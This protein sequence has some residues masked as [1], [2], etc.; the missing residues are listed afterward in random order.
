VAGHMEEENP[1]ADFQRPCS[2]S[3]TCVADRVR[4]LKGASI[5]AALQKEA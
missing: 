4:C 5:V 3:V 2:F 1:F